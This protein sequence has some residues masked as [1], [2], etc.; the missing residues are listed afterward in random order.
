MPSRELTGA[1]L[2]ENKVWWNG[3][4]FL[5]LPKSD[6]PNSHELDDTREAESELIKDTPVI[7]H[8]FIFYSYITKSCPVYVQTLVLLF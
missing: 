1:E 5:F 3:A 6:W 7:S 2:G 4:E 8:K